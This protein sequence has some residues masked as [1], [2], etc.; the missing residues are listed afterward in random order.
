[1]TLTATFA[2]TA[3]PVDND[4][5]PPYILYW[6]EASQTMQVGAWGDALTPSNYAAK[7][8]FFKFG[9]VVGFTNGA[10]WN[11]STSIKFNPSLT[12]IT[13]YGSSQSDSALPSIPSYTTTDYND[14]IRDV[15]SDIYHT[16][17]NVRAGKGDPCKLV[18]LTVAQIQAGLIDNGLY[19]LPTNSESVAFFGTSS[20]S[21]STT[22]STWTANDANATNPGTRTFHKSTPANAILPAAGFRSY[23]SGGGGDRGTVGYYRSSTPTNNMGGYYLYFSGANVYPSTY[24]NYS[25]DGMAVRCVTK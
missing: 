25:G 18:G 21:N 6:D 4:G 1:V 24:G 8:L 19:R 10:A 3:P 17:A 13:G 9:G 20:V 5:T 2:A 16:L 23:N 7:M 22:Y 12:A 14:G 11:T 15:S